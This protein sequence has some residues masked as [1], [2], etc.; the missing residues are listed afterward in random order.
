MQ[1]RITFNIKKLN[2]AF[3][4]VISDG[5]AR[6]KTNVFSLQK[7]DFYFPFPSFFLFPFSYL[8]SKF[9]FLSIFSFVFIFSLPFF[10]FLSTCWFTFQSLNYS[11]FAFPFL[12]TS[13]SFTFALSFADVQSWRLACWLVFFRSRS[14]EESSSVPPQE[15]NLCP[16]HQWLQRPSS[17]SIFC[18]LIMW[19][20]AHCPRVNFA[21]AW[22]SQPTVLP[23]NLARQ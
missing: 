18:S 2:P 20:H 6:M 4:A 8:F 9:S 10:A 13:S 12:L 5:K 21:W 3:N 22:A 11:F 17:L 14:V 23:N 19:S 7:I 16:A 1:Q 15:S